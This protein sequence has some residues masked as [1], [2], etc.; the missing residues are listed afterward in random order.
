M[1]LSGLY[2]Y[3]ISTRYVEKCPSFGVLK[4]ENGHFHAISGDFCI[5]PFSKFVRFGPFK[6]YSRVMFRA[7][8][9]KLTQKHVSRCLNPKFLV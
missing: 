8:G 6:K 2:L 3:K 1:A 7:L 4:V 5:F 9:E